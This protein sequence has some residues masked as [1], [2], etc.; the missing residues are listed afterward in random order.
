MSPLALLLRFVNIC[1]RRRALHIERVDDM[2]ARAGR[3]GE[4]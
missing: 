4:R 2:L 1:A 3:R